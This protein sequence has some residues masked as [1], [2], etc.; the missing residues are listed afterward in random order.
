ML[1]AS[2]A[3][4][5]VFFIGKTPPGGMICPEFKLLRAAHENPQ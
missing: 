5:I 2:N 3:A 1:N 4:L